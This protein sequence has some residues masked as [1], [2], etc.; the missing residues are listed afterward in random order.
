MVKKNSAVE[1]RLYPNK[2]QKVLLD[3]TFGCCRKV[4]NLALAECI[5]SYKETGLF[6][7]NNYP[8][9]FEEYPFLKEVEAQALNQSLQDLNRAFKNR[10][11]KTSKHK[12]DFPKFKSKRARQSYRTCQPRHNTFKDKVV[13][14]PKIGDIKYK[15]K[16][17]IGDNW[18]LKSITISKSPTGKYHAS[19]CYEYYVEEPHLE[20]DIQNSIGLDYKSDGLYVDNQGYKHDYPKFFRLY[21]S[22]LAYEQRKLSHMK[23]GSSN[24]YKQKLKVAKVHEKIT[25]CRKDF[26]RKLSYNLANTYDYVFVEDLNM[27]NISQCLKLGK[28]THDN[29]FGMFKSMLNYKLQDRGKVLHKIDKW[30]ASSTTCSNCSAKHKGIVNSL[31]I[32]KWTCPTC[33]CIHD[34]DINAAINIRQQ[35]IKETVGT[36]GLA[37][38]GLEQS[39]EQE[40]STL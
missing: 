11:S 14:I 10:F 39:I 9:Y 5:N 38:L 17:C 3:K 33:G 15:G 13:T 1:L 36:T 34:R 27:Q 35:G 4:W 29:S 6:K 18:K 37:C 31:S 8:S 32:R 12:T 30:Y 7:H 21:E 40:D 23:K 22:K 26:L 20:L 16:P 28:S 2:E 19:L 25:N 24:Y